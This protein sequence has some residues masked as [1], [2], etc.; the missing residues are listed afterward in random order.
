MGVQHVSPKEAYDLMVNEGYTY[1]DVRSVPEFT[2]GHAAQAVNIP[3]LHYD[4][5]TGWMVPNDD[6][7]AVVEGNFPKDVK[8]V[9]GCQVGQRSAQAAEILQQAGYTSVYNVRGGFGGLRDSFGRVIERGWAEIGLPVSYE[10]GEGV[11]YESLE[12]KMKGG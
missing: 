10:N 5:D 7:L 6:F 3:L 8:L 11:G 9:V 2:D 4:E 12:A 1:V